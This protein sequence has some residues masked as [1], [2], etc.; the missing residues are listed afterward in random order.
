MCL[1]KFGTF[2][3]KYMQIVTLKMTYFSID[4][5]IKEYRSLPKNVQI[6]RPVF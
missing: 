6:Y 5:N 3:L 1:R 2:F 4:N